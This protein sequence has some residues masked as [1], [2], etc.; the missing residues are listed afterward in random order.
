VGGT[1]RAAIRVRRLQRPPSL[2]TT[3]RRAPPARR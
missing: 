2:V 1:L 3:G